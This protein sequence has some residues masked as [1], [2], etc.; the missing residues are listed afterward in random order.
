MGR[1]NAVQLRLSLAVGTAKKPLPAQ[2]RNSTEGEQAVCGR[3]GGVSE[4]GK[5]DFSLDKGRSERKIAQTVILIRFKAGL[6]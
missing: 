4:Q 6:V 3:E 2:V 5:S 1:P